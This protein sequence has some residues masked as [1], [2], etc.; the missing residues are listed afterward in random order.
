MAVT[1]KGLNAFGAEVDSGGVLTLGGGSILT[2]GPGAHALFA[3][4]SGSQAN[5]GGAE[6]PL[7]SRQRGDRALCREWGRRHGD[8]AG[9]GQDERRGPFDHARPG[10]RFRRRCR[11]PGFSSQPRG[12]DHY[13]IGRRRDR[14]LGQRCCVERR[15][16]IDHG[17]RETQHHDCERGGCHR[18]TGERRL[19]RCDWRGVHRFGG[20]RDRLP[21]RKQS[22]RDLRQ[23]HHRQPDRRSD[24][25]RSVY[26][27]GQFL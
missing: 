7:N 10:R 18:A 15:R 5:L 20:R 17:D 1:T 19:D 2:Q 26:R 3:S 23:F 22:D 6:S 4:G 16:R 27:D 14:A 25:R 13:D 8:G 9:Y 12:G 11:R 24:L 21:R